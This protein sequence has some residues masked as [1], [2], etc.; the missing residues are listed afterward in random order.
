[1]GGIDRPVWM[2][3]LV[4]LVA[5]PVQIVVATE[6]LSVEAAQKAVFPQA[7]RFN[8][9]VLTLS[10]AQHERVAALAGPQPPHR[11]LR[12]FRALH[13]DFSVYTVVDR[14]GRPDAG[15]GTAV[16]FLEY[17]LE[18]GSKV[19][20]HWKDMQHVL[21]VVQS[22]KSGKSTTLLASK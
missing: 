14:C 3:A 7:D 1:M 13:G 9:M 8:E 16:G 11:S 18:D 20:I 15:G 17:H 5:A 6:Y 22:D 10:P 19:T 21:D 2:G 12:A 4:G